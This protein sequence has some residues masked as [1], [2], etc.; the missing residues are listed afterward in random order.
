MPASIPATALLL[1]LPTVGRH[2]GI[3]Y[4]LGQLFFRRRQI[5]AL[6]QRFFCC[7]NC[8]R[9]FQRFFFRYLN[10]VV[11]DIDTRQWPQQGLVT[12]YS[13]LGLLCRVFAV[14]QFLFLFIQF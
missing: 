11:T 6:C 3:A 7:L 13:L 8:L 2:R 4:L 1:L 14:L 5:A 10:R 12:Q 9:I